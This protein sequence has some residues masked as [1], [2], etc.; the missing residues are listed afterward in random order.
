[1]VSGV[2]TEVLIVAA[3]KTGKRYL[4]VLETAKWFKC[5]IDEAELSR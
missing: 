5:Q 4:V 3:N 2:K 1:M